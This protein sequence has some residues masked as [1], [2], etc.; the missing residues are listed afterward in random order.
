MRAL[1]LGVVLILSACTSSS[2]PRA[3]S[4]IQPSATPTPIA[5]TPTPTAG[6]PLMWAAPVRVDH[7][8]SFG[9]T[10]LS[11]VSCPSS[12]LC[13]AVD[14]AGNLVASSNHTGGAAAWKVTKVDS[15]NSLSGVACPISGLCV[16]VDEVGNVVTSNNPTAGAAAWKVT[17]VDGFN[18]LSGPSCPSSSLCVAVDG[19]GDVVTSSSP[20]G[21]AAA[22]R[23]IHAEWR[24]GVVGCVGAGCGVWP[25]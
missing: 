14:N 20:T 6:S 2:A 8:P 21:G 11:D 4:S 22:W 9:G 7:Q 16:A 10:S 1:V 15:S 24:D 5:M 25:R 18:S 12:G 19:A 13:F 3:Q 23:V 17:K